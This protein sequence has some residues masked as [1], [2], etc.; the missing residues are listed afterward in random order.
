[1][2]FIKQYNLLVSFYPMLKSYKL[3]TNFELINM[4]VYLW[5]LCQLYFTNKFLEDSIDMFSH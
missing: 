4:S 5:T 2:N 3:N 1:M